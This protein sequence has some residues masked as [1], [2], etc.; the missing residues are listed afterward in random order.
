MENTK[1]LV[2]NK[3]LSQ[4]KFDLIRPVG[5]IRPWLYGLPKLHKKDVTLGLSISMIRSLLDF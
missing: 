2:K 1:R 3:E 4:E 5:S